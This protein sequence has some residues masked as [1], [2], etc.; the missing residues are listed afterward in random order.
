MAVAVANTLLSHTFDYWRTRTNEMAG[1][2]ST[3]V[4]T[5]GVTN[6]GNVG[7]NG[8][9]L[10]VNG[11][12]NALLTG[13]SLSITN[14]SSNVTIT[15]PTSTQVS[16]GQF[17]LNA[18]GSWNIIT[19]PYVNNATTNT[20]GTSAQLIDT[21]STTIFNSAE[22]LINVADNVDSSNYYTT[23][24]LVMNTTTNTYI[25]DYGGLLSNAAVGA[26][27]ANANATHVKLY[28]TPVSSNTKVRYT[29]I[30]V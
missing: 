27:S 4:V 18:N 19:L 29:R 15:I 16:N 14:S 25:T 2:M 26:F 1:Y 8:N 28:F 17:W 22:Y 24:L 5:T 23:K 20:S 7:F 30:T 12:S 10:V 3:I 6:S 13:T 21:F 11:S 9:V